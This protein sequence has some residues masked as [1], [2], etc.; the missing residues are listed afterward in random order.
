[1][2]GFLRAHWAPLV[3]GAGI[4]AAAWLWFARPA[5][6]DLRRAESELARLG[7][8]AASAERAASEAASRGPVLEVGGMSFG[9]G[10]PTGVQE[11][12]HE[13]AQRSGVSVV[14]LDPQRE[15]SP[16]AI[17]PFRYERG[18]HTVEAEGAYADI[19]AYLS[20]LRSEPMAAVTDFTLSTSR[21]N[22][23]T[24]LVATVRTGAASHGGRAVAEGALE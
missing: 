14:R 10:G 18:A 1:M 6:E 2:I 19:A 4:G 23:M 21:R 24:G 3:I 9:A 13:L 16:E 20:L 17:G 11:R 22:G 12:F 8:A 5:V 7:E 15:A